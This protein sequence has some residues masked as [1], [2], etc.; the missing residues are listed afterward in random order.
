MST[1]E[2]E[3]YLIA[4]SKL[5]RRKSVDTGEISRSFEE[6]NDMLPDQVKSPEK[7]KDSGPAGKYLHLTCLCRFLYPN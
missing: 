1:L 3:N 5:L 6:K 4:P 7:K 2:P